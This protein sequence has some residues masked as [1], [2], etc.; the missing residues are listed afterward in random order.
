MGGEVVG[1]RGDLDGAAAE[2]LISYMVKM[3][4]Q[5][6]ASVLT[7]SAVLSASSKRTGTRS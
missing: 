7:S 2:A 3:T 4:G 5:C 1:E 6:R